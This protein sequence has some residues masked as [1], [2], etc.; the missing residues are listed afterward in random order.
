MDPLTWV[1][2]HYLVEQVDELSTAHP[3]VTAEVEAFLEDSNEVSKATPEELILLYHDL[4][5]VAARHSKET[6]VDSTVAIEGQHS[7]LQR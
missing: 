1:Q 6:K 5:V 7:T 4:R 3:F 2:A